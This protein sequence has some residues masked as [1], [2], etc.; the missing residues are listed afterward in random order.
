[1]LDHSVVDFHV[2]AT[3]SRWA[4]IAIARNFEDK[5]VTIGVV[6][7]LLSGWAVHE[8]TSVGFAKRKGLPYITLLALFPIDYGI[9]YHAPCCNN[10]GT[11]GVSVS[12]V[13]SSLFV[14]RSNNHGAEFGLLF[15]TVGK[16]FDFSKEHYAVANRSCRQRDKFHIARESN[17][18]YSSAMAHKDSSLSS[19]SQPLS[20]LWSCL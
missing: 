3:W 17:E 6:C 19:W 20:A 12:F 13:V 10:L 14:V 4:A 18:L 5:W 2:P 11:R 16:Q 7:T 9:M 15:A 8:G 1:M